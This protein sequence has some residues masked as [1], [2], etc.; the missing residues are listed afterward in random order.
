[1]LLAGLTPAHAENGKDSTSLA[2]VAPETLRD[3]VLAADLSRKANGSLGKS[4][5]TK[6]VTVP[7]NTGQP[8]SISSGDATLDFYL[9]QSEKRIKSTVGKDGQ[10]QF[11]NGDD[12]LTNVLPKSDGSLQIA[13]TIVSE[14]A[15][16]TYEYDLALD[17]GSTV[18]SLESGGIEILSAEG[19]FVGGLAAPWAR[20]AAGKEIP[21]AYEV[22]GNSIVQL[23]DHGAG[24]DITYPVVADPWLGIDLYNQPWVQFV[25]Q[26]YKIN[27]VPTSWGT[28]YR[29]IEIW[30]AHRDEIV[31]KLGS[32]SWR[33][34]N[35]IQEQLYCHIYGWPQSAPEYNLESWRPTINWAESIAKYRC[36][37]YDGA[38]S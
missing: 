30:W 22:R 12:S 13:T 37:P 31:T 20:D 33:W 23:V 24:K 8:A 18:R 6:S 16:T 15:P 36:N 10:V 21:T 19:K 32:Q 11:N 7:G 27:V 3:T 17:S 2:V 28:T 5:G 38:W 25:S 35:S 4:L 29:G 14:R 9:P 1:M 26:G 34:N